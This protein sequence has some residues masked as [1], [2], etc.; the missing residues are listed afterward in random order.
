M[1]FIINTYDKINAVRDCQR[2]R[3]DPHLIHQA[4][5]DFHLVQ[6]FRHLQEGPLSL[7]S[8]Q[9]LDQIPLKDPLGQRNHAYLGS[10]S[11]QVH[12]L[13]LLPGKIYVDIEDQ[14]PD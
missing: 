4:T 6:L 2:S 11:L 9:E 5:L 14:D 7:W 3:R 12:Q 13:D 10:P 1:V 8:L